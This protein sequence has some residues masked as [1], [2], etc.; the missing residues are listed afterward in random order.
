[1]ANRYGMTSLSVSRLKL[2]S[3]KSLGRDIEPERLES[4]CIRSRENLIGGVEILATT[5]VGDTVHQLCHLPDL[6]AQ[7]ILLVE[8]MSQSRRTM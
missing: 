8:V 5:R 1:M 2:P 3:L 4:L 6:L 7:Q